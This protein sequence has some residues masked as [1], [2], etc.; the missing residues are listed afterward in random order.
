M[1]HTLGPRAANS[2]FWDGPGQ[3]P[4][5]PDVL[6]RIE[7]LQQT[8][9]GDI[10]HFVTTSLKRT[11]DPIVITGLA[12]H[13]L[14]RDAVRTWLPSAIEEASARLVAKAQRN[15][16]VGAAYAAAAKLLLEQTLADDT[17][18]RIFDFY[19][20]PDTRFLQFVDS[21]GKRLTSE[22]ASQ[23]YLPRRPCRNRLIIVENVNEVDDVALLLPDAD[24]STIL[25]TSDTF[26]RADFSKYAAWPSV[27]EIV[28]EHIRTRIPRFSQPYVDLH[29]ETA[30]LAQRVVAEVDS[31]SD[32]VSADIRPLLEV[33]VADLI[34]FQALKAQA[35]EALLQ[36][37]DFDHI[38]VGFDDLSRSLE[39]VHLISSVD[40]LLEDARTELASLS[41]SAPERAR[42]WTLIGELDDPSNPVTSPYARIPESL[43]L[44]KF[45]QDAHRLAGTLTPLECGRRPSVLVVTSS[46]VS[47][48]ESTAEYIRELENDFD[49]RLL[50]TGG[51][52]GL[53][54]DA[55]G[56]H[57]PAT[58]D[59]LAPFGARFTPLADAL[60]P[61]LRDL[62]PDD[63]TSPA[64]AAAS[65]A[66]R[67]SAHRIVRESLGPTILSAN[68]VDL[69]LNEAARNAGLPDAIVL[70]PQR[71]VSVSLV[72]PLARRFGI[73]TLA[74]EPH[75][76]DANYSRY[77]KVS[78]DYYGVMSDYFRTQ[79]AETF[80]IDP[81][82]S[83][84]IGSP[85]QVA[86]PGYDPDEDQR[87]ARR[88]FS[89]THGRVFDPETTYVV[90]FCQPSAWDHVAKIWETI[91]RAAEAN[92]CI[93]LLKTHPEESVS[94]AQQYL[95]HADSI[96]MSRLV[97]VLETDAAAAIAL[98]D[99]VV[100]AYSSGAYDAVIRQ[101]PVVCVTD[102]EVRYPVDLPAILDAPLAR[103]VE[104]LSKIISEF[105]ADPEEFRRRARAF[106]ER[107]DHF[108]VGPG[109]RLREFVSEIIATGSAGVRRDD[110]VPGSLFSMARIQ[111]FASDPS[112]SW[113]R[114]R[115][116]G[117]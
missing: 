105:R 33:S 22:P 44:G 32:L 17:V 27:G 30:H 47:Y 80:G 24:K 59:R 89:D 114:S 10:S 53:L 31:I 20:I 5:W 57:A 3:R 29:V 78:A 48:N 4:T 16:F 116:R 1:H 43:V 11:K 75:A 99:L 68:A 50:S 55:L 64:Q 79:T 2:F 70:T 7:R 82:R 9:P 98:G 101:R 41:A 56:T 54:L 14:A 107:E 85:R 76:Q 91:L 94:R 100:T 35:I 46:S 26:G 81:T 66:I 6:D 51:D 21:L 23:S 67:Y 40:G 117:W 102:G 28:V 113:I 65:R 86:P 12:Q 90:F 103:S 72:A 62:G 95:D 49:V 37:Q 19:E 110:A 93:V 45:E 63:P 84:T 58:C 18:S 60:A 115:S 34:F 39:F 25:V 109:P 111:S 52:E 87:H 77:T 74:V 38:V 8:R 36:D 13:P 61:R 69:W 108:V 73:P 83:R 106:V 42:F 15:R 92:Q 71:T 97:V 96:G 88:D 112:S 104:E